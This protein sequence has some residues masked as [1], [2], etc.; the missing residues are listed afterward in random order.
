MKLIRLL[1]KSSSKNIFL[2]AIFSFLSGASG[3][4]IIAVIN[5]AVNNIEDLP[6]WV[7]WVFIGCCI[8]L[9]IFRFLSW[10]SINRL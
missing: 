2:A 10:V 3:G 6:P 4:G 9:W 5:Y 1:L 7:I 8:S